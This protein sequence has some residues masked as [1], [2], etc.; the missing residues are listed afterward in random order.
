[1]NF[2]DLPVKQQIAKLTEVLQPHGID[3]ARF[4]R[5]LK[6][7]AYRNKNRTNSEFQISSDD[8]L[9]TRMAIYRR[10]IVRRLRV[11]KYAYFV[12]TTIGVKYKIVCYQD[13]V[14]PLRLLEAFM[15]AYIEGDESI[16]SF[17]RVCEN[18]HKDGIIKKNRNSF[19]KRLERMRKIIKFYS[20]PPEWWKKYTD[21]K[22]DDLD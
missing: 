12:N 7:Y 9:S 16:D 14:K 22:S 8:G 6:K 1:M 19:N 10:F 21:L 11:E 18:F 3:F 4:L 15:N 20:I 2:H 13:G 5:A 17:M